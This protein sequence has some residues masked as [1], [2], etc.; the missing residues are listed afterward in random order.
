MNDTI[1]IIII[2]TI[3]NKNSLARVN[4]QTLLIITFCD[5]LKLRVVENKAMEKNFV[6]GSI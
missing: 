2:F 6:F 1:I 5:I 4:G 3:F